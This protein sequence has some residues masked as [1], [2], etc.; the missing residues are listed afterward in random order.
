MVVVVVVVVTMVVVVAAADVICFSI[1]MIIIGKQRWR[2]QAV[3]VG[4]YDG[5]QL[6]EIYSRHHGRAGGGCITKTTSQRCWI[7]HR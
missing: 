6:A 5:L 3:I 1:D 4:Q 2:L 7:G